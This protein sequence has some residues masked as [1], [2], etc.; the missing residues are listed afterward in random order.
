[1]LRAVHQALLDES[2]PKR[3]GGCHPARQRLSDFPR[4]VGAGPE[5]RHRAHVV[6]LP[7]CQSI[8]SNAKEALIE[9][10]GELLDEI[11]EQ[12][13]LL[14]M[15]DVMMLRRRLLRARPIHVTKLGGA[16]LETLA[17]QARKVAKDVRG[18]HVDRGVGA[19]LE[20]AAK[21]SETPRELL[22]R[23]MLREERIAWL[24]EA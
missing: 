3:T 15:E 9:G 23:V 8:E 13:T 10:G 6:S 17:A 14:P 16:E 7:G 20:H 1:M 4:A 24:G 18:K 19:F 21:D 12:T 11:E 5:L 2:R 22:R